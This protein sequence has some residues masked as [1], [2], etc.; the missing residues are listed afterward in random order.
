MTPINQDEPQLPPI[1]AIGD[2][3]DRKDRFIEKKYTVIKCDNCQAKYQRE[4]RPGD[5]TFK[6]VADE[7]CDKCHRKKITIQ[8]IYSEWIDPKKG[9]KKE[10]KKKK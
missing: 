8:E 6:K 3:I 5:F 9:P 10:K 1:P 4:F 2:I 7:E